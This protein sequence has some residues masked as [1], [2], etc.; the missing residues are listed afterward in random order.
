M[1]Y[2]YLNLGLCCGG[3]SFDKGADLDVIMISLSMQSSQ[4]KQLLET[5]RCRRAKVSS[6]RMFSRE[7]I[8]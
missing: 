5:A 4:R 2:A 1:R 7:L 8:S 3:S 6:H